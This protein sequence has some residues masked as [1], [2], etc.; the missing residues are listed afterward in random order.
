M[1]LIVGLIETALAL[2][3]FVIVGRFLMSWPPMRSGTLSY[4]VYSVLYNCERAVLAHLQTVSP[5]RAV[6]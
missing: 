2:Y 3:I 6:W 1:L 5:A 4:R